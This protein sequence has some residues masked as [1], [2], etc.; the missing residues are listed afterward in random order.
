[1][2]FKRNSFK[3]ISRSWCFKFG[4]CGFLVEQLLNIIEKQM[5]PE[6]VLMIP[7]SPKCFDSVSTFSINAL[8]T[9]KKQFVGD[10]K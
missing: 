5:G 2:F 8:F 3:N 9:R 7:L 1:M 6:S 10:L 4:K